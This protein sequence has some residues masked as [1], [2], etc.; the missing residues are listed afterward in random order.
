MN[1]IT[2]AIIGAST[3]TVLFILGR[4]FQKKD[5][6]VTECSTHTNRIVELERR[7]SVV[8]TNIDGH[9][10]EIDEIKLVLIDIQKDIK[11]ILL[12]LS[13]NNHI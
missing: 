8:E 2:A 4:V 1:E 3:A 7:V 10:K 13:T 9:E 6:K 12:R 5:T 11:T